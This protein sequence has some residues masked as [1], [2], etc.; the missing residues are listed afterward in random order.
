M[1]SQE[2]KANMTPP[3]TPSLD[4][5]RQAAVAAEQPVVTPAEPVIPATPD[6]WQVKTVDGGN[7]EVTVEGQVYKGT[8][9]Q[10]L[11]ELAKAQYHATHT[12][13]DTR[14]ELEKLKT[15]APAPVVAPTTPTEPQEV[16]AARQY[17]ADE[18]AKALGFRDAT[19]L[20]QS[21]GAMTGVVEN[22]S[23]NSLVSGFFQLVPEFP[24]NNETVEK[25]FKVQEAN[26][27]PM[28]PQGL[29]AAHLIAVAEKQY[30]P[31]TPE[32]IKVQQARALGI[33][34][35]TLVPPTAAPMVPSSSGLQSQGTFNP[36]DPKIPLDQV[37]Q[38]A[39]QAERK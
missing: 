7:Y 1:N 18:T 3:V 31:L 29:R 32:Q 37:K 35:G 17:L 33:D 2:K 38:W 30:A 24:D 4:D 11:Q 25:L 39:Q 28:T 9:Q 15:P 6:P 20:K 14:T 8:H 21:I 22:N 34:V 13:R 5:L 16:I 36:Y 26:G 10:V 12:I 27:L 19:E 23:Q